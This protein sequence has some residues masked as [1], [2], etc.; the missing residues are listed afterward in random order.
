MNNIDEIS[1]DLIIE[2]YRNEPDKALKFTEN[3]YGRLCRRL[4]SNFL[5][6][7]EDAEECYNDFLLNMWRSVPEQQP[8]NLKA[9]SCRVAR[10]HAMKKLEYNHS[11]K[12]DYPRTSFDELCEFISDVG[13]A[14]EE[15]DG[16]YL[17]EQI[18]TFLSGLP[19]LERQV[20]V[21]R[22]FFGYSVKEIA[23]SLDIVSF[24][25]SNM[26]FRSKKQL[27]AFLEKN[28]CI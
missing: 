10:N 26:L 20:F 24:R 23:R 22:F 6:V 5:R 15:Y 17:R 14:E 25:I 19:E 16:T 27:R 2:L 21:K 7:P 9:F 8:D 28:N 3:K 12:R 4:I 13:N 1:D 18:N 11:Q